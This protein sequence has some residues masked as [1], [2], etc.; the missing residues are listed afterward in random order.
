MQD[1]D[2]LGLV[3]G[4]LADASGYDSDKVATDQADALN[5][6]F[7]RP[8]GD[9][10]AGRSQVV[11]GDLSA[12]VE[13][14]LAQ[15]MDAFSTDNIVEFESTGPEDED[16]CQLESDTVSH[17]V[18]DE[19]PGFLTFIEGI[20]DALLL[21]NGISKVWVKDNLQV[22]VV[23]YTDVAPEAQA[24]LLLPKHGFTHEVVKWDKNK[25]TLK[26]R[27]TKRGQLLKIDS[28]PVENFIYTKNWTSLN[29]QDIPIC[30]ERHTEIRSDLVDRGFDKEVVAGLP[31]FA[32]HTTVA[33]GARNPRSETQ[34]QKQNIDKS[35]DLIE[36]YE[37]YVLTDMDDDGIAERHSISF[38]P[39]HAVL[40]SKPAKF[41]PYAAGA[42][43]IN[44]HR[45]LGISLYDKL[46][47]V[48]DINTGLNRALLD[49]AN[50][51][52]KSRTAYLDGKVNTDDLDNG[53]VDGNIR[54]GG[55]GAQGSVADVRTAITAFTQPDIS[56]GILANIQHQDKKRAELGGAALDMA[57]A[58]IQLSDNAGSQGIDRAYSVM[59]QIAALMTR[60]VAESLIRNTYILAHATLRQFFDQPVDI[61]R[62]GKWD[63]SIPRDWP[64]RKRLNVKIGMSPGERSRKVSALGFIIKTQLDLAGQGM[65][66]VLVSIRGFYSALMD[67]GRASEIDNPEQY[68][69]DPASDES[70]EALQRKEAEA[71]QETDAQRKLTDV[72]LGL[73]QLRI[74]M[75]KYKT[76]KDSVVDVFKAV[77]GA[78]TKTGEIVG[79]ALIKMLMERAEE[80]TEQVSDLPITSKTDAK[81]N[82]V[83]KLPNGKT[84]TVHHGDNDGKADE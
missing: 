34:T 13:A 72:A 81:G 8:R 24:E 79:D 62:H 54:V 53:L 76:D 10:K 56:A 35:L 58:N 49:N 61:K 43:L 20:K 67:W 41:V 6:Y 22:E 68:F 75:D 40:E 37:T 47:Q 82:R 5:Y 12:M 48:Q 60:I 29:L 21:R 25:G 39:N 14:N 45:F 64:E 70:K 7:M 23:D 42:V 50:V 1:K 83:F 59:E 15:M 17:Y 63:A 71:K 28:V 31:A 2:I 32:Q 80:V 11:S 36:W 78:E 38:V 26:L 74:G 33:G 27:K 3:T 77:L 69:V 65:D 44:P 16:Q 9:E 30:G 19:N 73:E 84:I 4:L 55:T 66:D 46:K 51:S 18:M 57:S 52:N